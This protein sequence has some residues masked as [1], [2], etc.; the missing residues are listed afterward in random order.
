VDHF[1]ANRV[2]YNVASEFEKIGLFLYQYRFE[3]ALK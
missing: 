1:S 3:A 2:K